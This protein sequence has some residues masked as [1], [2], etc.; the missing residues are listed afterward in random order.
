MRSP[1][2]PRVELQPPPAGHQSLALRSILDRL[3]H[4]RRPRVLDL[5]RAAGANVEFFAGH[6]CSLYIADLYRSLAGEGRLPPDPPRLDRALDEQL[7]QPAT[8]PFDLILAWD[9]IN[10]FDPPR[11][12]V[13]GHRL[14]SLCRPGGQMLAL[15]A[16]RDRIADRPLAFSIRDAGNLDYRSSATGEHPPPRYIEAQLE[17]LL[18]SFSVETTYL[19]RN[20]I[21]EYVFTRRALPGRAAPG[22]APR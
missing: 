19:L 12:E 18:P 21:Q 17:R 9:L 11:L 16:T 2:Q 4:R 7:P 10:Y 13:L 3:A 8:G 6:G 1:P 15:I 5:G 14:G 22:A 20:G